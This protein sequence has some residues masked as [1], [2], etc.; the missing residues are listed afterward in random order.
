MAEA[1]PLLSALDDLLRACADEDWAQAERL[2]RDHDAQVRQALASRDPQL[3][4]ELHRV[5]RAQQTVLGE[6]GRHRDEAARQLG[7]LQRSGVAARAYLTS[8]GSGESA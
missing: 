3:I 5:C 4:A 8:G 7:Q 6:L 1:S 2:V